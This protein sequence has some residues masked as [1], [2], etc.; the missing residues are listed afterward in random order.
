M[1]MR[2]TL[3]THGSRC[4]FLRLPGMLPRPRV[5]DRR[6]RRLHMW[7]SARH[8]GM[9]I[10]GPD[11]GAAVPPPQQSRQRCPSPGAARLG[12]G[13]DRHESLNLSASLNLSE[14][15]VG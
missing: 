6:A 14:L 11:S 12:L 9:V 8:E 2:P 13:L 1:C 5:K 7:G 3:I 15:V 4:S 10:D